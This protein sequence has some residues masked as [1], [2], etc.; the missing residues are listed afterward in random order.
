MVKFPRHD[1]A[2]YLDTAAELAEQVAAC[3][4]QIDR[5]RQLPADLAGEFADKGFFRFLLPR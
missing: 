2:Y 1:I 5:D 3:A 4:D